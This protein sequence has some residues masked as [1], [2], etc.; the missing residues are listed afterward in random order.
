MG[1]FELEGVY[2]DIES[3]IIKKRNDSQEKVGVSEEEIKAVELAYNDEIK[4]F[5]SLFGTTSLDNLDWSVERD[6]NSI[7]NKRWMNKYH[8]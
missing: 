3:K 1:K 4:E 7:L 8:T 6:W 5:K 2:M